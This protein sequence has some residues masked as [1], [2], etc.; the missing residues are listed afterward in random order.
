MPSFAEVF[1]VKVTTRA[2]SRVAATGSSLLR[3]FGMQP[4]GPAVTRIDGRDFNYD[5]FN[6]S[7]SVA[8]GR[9]PGAPAGTVNL[10]PTGKVS[11]TLPRL[12]EKMVLP[13]E[14]LNIVR[15]MGSSNEIDEAG[16]DYTR[17][18]QA[19]LGQRAANFRLLQL[20]G[21]MRGTL[22]AH[23]SGEDIYYDFTNSSVSFSIDWR[24]PSGNLLRLNMLGGGNIIDKSWAD[25]TA[26]IPGHVAQV[27]AASVQLTGREIRLAMCSLSMWEIIKGND[28]VQAKAGIASVAFESVPLPAGVEAA[29]GGQ[30]IAAYRLSGMPEVTW[31]VTDQG[32]TLGA[33]GS[34]YTK[35]VGD[36]DVWFGPSPSIDQFQMY[37]GSEMVVVRGNR[38]LARGLFSYTKETDDPA[39]V[40][41]YTVDNVL[42]TNFL[43]AA[44]AYATPIF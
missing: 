4:N 33:S 32:L 14:K 30:P 22:Y 12:N 7:R 15:R 35:L 6:A 38:T 43:P 39:A 5:I 31:I 25:P 13:Y 36:T 44:C 18:Q 8:T 2:V 28:N 11:G 23:Q 42:V 41:M 1:D 26:D 29:S 16:L 10:Q 19:I 27:R 34:T 24:I 20:A 9:G 40:L 3:L 21:M 17:N 37:E